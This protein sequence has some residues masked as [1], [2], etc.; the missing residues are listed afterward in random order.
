MF[1]K[2]NL[3]MALC[4][5]AGCSA[6]QANQSQNQNQKIVQIKQ[7]LATLD[8]HVALEFSPDSK[9]LA[10]GAELI[11]AGT[12]KVSAMLDKRISNDNPNSKNH[13][14]YVSV[15]FSPDS[16][17]VAIGEEVGVIRILEIPSMVLAKEIKAHGA[18][19]TG[20]GFGTDNETIVTTSRDET[21]RMWN[22]RTGSEL[23]RTGDS[24]KP[25][26]T[27]ATY[28]GAVDAFALS[29]SREM[30]AAV[31]LLTNLVVIGSMRDGSILHKFKA[32]GGQTITPSRADIQA[33]AI[34]ACAMVASAS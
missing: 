27:I 4:L 7:P 33:A 25:E 34:S 28:S 17:K 31:D 23:H 13:W 29:P 10:I 22:T 16:K 1:A 3:V 5:L 11:E 24:A 30:F 21:I 32:P 12:W 26:G 9:W 15:A 2:R 8:G 14:G 19:V 20:I 6:K 18:R